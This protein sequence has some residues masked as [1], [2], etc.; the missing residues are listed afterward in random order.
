M[1][2]SIVYVENTKFPGV[3]SPKITCLSA[4]TK[5]EKKG[6]TVQFQIRIY[7]FTPDF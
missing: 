7:L 6:S 2:S 1:E 4:A 3:K 5:D